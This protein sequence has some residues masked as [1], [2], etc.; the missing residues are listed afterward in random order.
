MSRRMDVY[1]GI[2]EMEKAYKGAVV[3]LGVYDGLHRAHMQIID[4][5]VESAQQ[6]ETKSMIITFDPH[7]RNV[8]SPHNP[9][10][11]SLTTPSEKI[12][13]LNDTALDG[14]LFL[15]V[16]ADLLNTA[17]EEFV[18]TLLV[19]KL[20]A[21]KV[22]VGYDYHFGKNRDGKPDQLLK[23]GRKYGF[24]VEIIAPIRLNET[25]IRSS[26]IRALL[27][28]GNVEKAAELLGRPYS[29]TGKVVHGSGR[30]RTLGFPTANIKPAAT[31]KMIPADGIY[32]T[33]CR[34]LETTYFGICNIGVR[35]TFG[36]HDRVIEIYLMDVDDVDL[37]G[38]GFEMKFLQRLRDEIKFG[39]REELIEQMKKDE[40]ECRDRI[41]KYDDEME[42]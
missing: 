26:A 42:D 39:T 20:R 27:S 38:T 31:D 8:L 2:E 6:L 37:Y 16:D 32:L 11:K 30:G 29:I 33:K 1:Y 9:P 3:T 24:D 28:D 22:I 5:V 35:K 4:H 7:P 19:D 18:R 34:V 36:E 17:S 25:T 41:K 40:I 10:V 15:N 23:Y 14:V 12:T 13:A 21:R